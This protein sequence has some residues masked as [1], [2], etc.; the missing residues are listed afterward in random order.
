MGSNNY[1]IHPSSDVQ[2]KNIGKDTTIWQFVVILKDAV[3]GE[4]VNVNAH[5]FIENDVEIDKRGISTV[6]HLV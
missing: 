3:L 6:V 4:N 2:T 1:K 5:C